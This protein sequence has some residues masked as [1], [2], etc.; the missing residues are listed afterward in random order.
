MIDLHWSLPQLLFLLPLAILPWFNHNQEKTV[1]WVD[2]VPVDPL[3]NTIGFMLKLL[4]S[5]A[6]I[7]LLFAL[8]GPYKPEQ[9]I[10]KIAAGAEI[11][12]LLDRSRSMDDA[13]AIKGQLLM[14]SVAKS[15]SKRRTA[16]SYLTE[17]VK[18][19]P[20]DRFGFV[21]FSTKAIDLLPLTYSK[22][23]ILATINAS[24]LGKG[25]SE[26]NMSKA[27]LEAANLYQGQAYRGS[28]IVLLVS[29]GGQELDAQDKVKIAM[30]Y[31][32]LNISIYWIYM[33]S[34]QGMTLDET[35][36][37]NFLW[38]D[39]PE[40]KLHT[41]F[42]SLELPYRAFEVESVKTFSEAIDEID[43]QQY[44]TLIIEQTLPR[45]AKE[46]PFYWLALMTLL[47]LS[48]AQM[49]TAWG[50]RTAHE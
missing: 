22:E 45:E 49:Y 25:L 13:F 2:F 33:R 50:V 43:R 48:L 23:A 41:Y 14:K 32:E 36:N 46:K 10:D 11:V 39:T 44:Q 37:D 29:D 20:D 17:F 26:T 18:K 1:A 12:L 6:I 35:E 19:R 47:L 7:S 3:S 31:K 27:L 4:A 9:K 34:S 15:D 42:K 21:F 38:T 5:L 28:R 30:L 40:R 24:A 8:A 16:R